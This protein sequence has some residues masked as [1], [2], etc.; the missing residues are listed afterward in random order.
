ME[1]WLAFWHSTSCVTK[2]SF[3]CDVAA[4]SCSRAFNSSDSL[5]FSS[6]SCWLVSALA[7]VAF[8]NTIW[9]NEITAWSSVSIHRRPRN[10]NMLPYV[11][12]QLHLTKKNCNTAL[13]ETLIYSHLHVLYVHV[14]SAHFVDLGTHLTSPFT[15]TGK[16]MYQY[17]F[18]W[19][20]WVRLKG[21]NPQI[22]RNF[23]TPLNITDTFYLNIRSNNSAFHPLRNLD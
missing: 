10:V 2:S 1:V 11:I 8:Q 5:L 9:H 20:Q 15:L 21:D 12:I 16:H 14:W 4:N 7:A 3:W 13:K 19:F 22:W 23:L 17:W 18:N 6:T